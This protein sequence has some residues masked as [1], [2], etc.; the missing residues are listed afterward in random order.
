MDD[1]GPWQTHLLLGGQFP[2]Q[3]IHQAL[4]IVKVF[5]CRTL[6]HHCS[7]FYNIQAQ[8]DL[9]T[10]NS[11]KTNTEHKFPLEQYFPRS[12]SISLPGTDMNLWLNLTCVLQSRHSFVPH[13]IPCL[14][15]GKPSLW[16]KGNNQVNQSAAQTAVICE[17]QDRI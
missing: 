3:M 10:I 2:L 5:L 8:V 7:A 9:M 15:Y 4:H 13:G 16:V 1:K 6:T 11:L 17:Q 12:T 14:G